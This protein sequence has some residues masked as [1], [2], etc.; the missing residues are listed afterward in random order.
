VHCR[1][2]ASTEYVAILLVVAALLAV[3]AV[4]LPGVGERVVAAVRTAICIAGGDVCRRSDAAAAGLEPC[5]TRARSSRTE[6][7]VDVAFVRLGENGEWQLTLRSDG[8]AL[9]SRLDENEAG[10]TGGIGFTFSP[11]GIDA[12]AE[13]SIVGGYR[14]GRA[15]RFRDA[16]AAAAF[17]ADGDHSRPPDVRWHALGG[18]ADG[19]AGFDTGAEL[20]RA[21][22]TASFASALGLRD[23]G[24]RRTLTLDLGLEEPDL[25]IELPGFPAAPGELRE[26]VAEVT[27]ERGRLRELAVRMAAGDRERL[28]EFSGRLDLRAAGNRAFA[29][30]LL[31]APTA[32]RL[33]ALWRRIIGHGVVEYGGYRVS[34]RRRGFNVAS[35]LGLALGVTHQRIAS[36]RRLVDALAWIRGGPQQ[37]R[38]DCLGV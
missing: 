22:L 20:A 26:L 13:A 6:T 11:A 25:G 19:Y 29:A 36:E 24:R 4:A 30:R 21:G 28:E 12:A 10:M 18:H 1:G 31:G 17:I 32:G 33:R 14:G 9:V 37:R 35:R 34:E 16:R 8:G 15:W 5:V 27:W 38:F 7:A 2:Q 3:A 23:D